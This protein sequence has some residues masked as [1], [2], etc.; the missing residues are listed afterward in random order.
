MCRPE[1]ENG[2]LREQPLTENGCMCGGG[3]GGHSEWPLTE[4]LG[5]FG[6]KNNK[7]QY[8]F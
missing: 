2:E 8:F 6:I 1:F 7:P 4:K 5:D 3:G